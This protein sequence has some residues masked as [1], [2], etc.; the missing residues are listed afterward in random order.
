M[1][2]K[3]VVIRQL[4]SSQ[5]MM[6]MMMIWASERRMKKSFSLGF[7]TRIGGVQMKRASSSGGR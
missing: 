6:M 7:G 1:L 2:Q 3:L 4:C 5:A